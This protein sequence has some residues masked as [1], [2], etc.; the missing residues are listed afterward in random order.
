M[1]VAVIANCQAPGV[2]RSV[3]F[4]LPGASVSHFR[5]NDIKSVDRLS[6]VADEL[7]GFDLILSQ[8]TE[9]PFFE[10]LDSSRLLERGLNAKSFPPVVFQGFHP[11]MTYLRYSG[12]EL[13][14]PLDTYHS[15]LVAACFLKGIEAAEVLDHFNA[16]N[17]ARFGYFDAYEQSVGLFTDRCSSFGIELGGYLDGWL[18]SGSFMHTINHPRVCVIAAIVYELL[19]GS[20]LNPIAYSQADQL[21][22]DD[23]QSGIIWPVYPEIASRLKIA[24]SMVFKHAVIRGEFKYLQAQQLVNE[25]YEKYRSIDAEALKA[26]SV[27]EICDLL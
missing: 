11:D 5:Y 10:S 18:R 4:F 13:T 1:K 20:G 12:K 23:L 9:N 17:F 8:Y 25:Y 22:P 16:F 26:S 2:A 15:R 21:I 6:A 3:R 7:K 27:T 19:Q 14:G 24:G